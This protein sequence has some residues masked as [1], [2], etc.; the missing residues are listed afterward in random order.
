MDLEKEHIRA[1]VY[2]D[3]KKGVTYLECRNETV[4]VL[5]HCMVSKKTILNWFHQF[6]R[7][8]ENLKDDRPITSIFEVRISAV[9]DMV[10]QNPKVIYPEIQHNL[11]ISADS[12][13][14]IF[15]RHLG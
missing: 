12:L 3:W 11:K 8:Q 15:H 10:I 4:G 14:A 1:I 13:Y 9:R 6:S 7:V 5:G 2:F